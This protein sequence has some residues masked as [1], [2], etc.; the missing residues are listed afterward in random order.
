MQE[1][2]KQ[3]LEKE[4]LLNE[5]LDSTIPKPDVVDQSSNDNKEL[6][7]AKK[8]KQ[9]VDKLPSHLGG[10]Q[11]NGKE[12]GNL[13]DGDNDLG[14]EEDL[15]LGFRDRFVNY[16]SP[17]A[18]RLADFPSGLIKDS[19][20]LVDWM[21]GGPSK[22]KPMT[23]PLAKLINLLSK[24]LGFDKTFKLIQDSIAEDKLKNNIVPDKH[25]DPQKD[26]NL[27]ENKSAQNSIK[28]DLDP[29]LDFGRTKEQIAELEKNGASQ[30]NNQGNN[31]K[32]IHNDL[33]Q[34]LLNDSNKINKSGVK[35]PLI[36]DKSSSSAQDPYQVDNAN[37]D[38]QSENSPMKYKMNHVIR[39]NGVVRAE[40]LPMPHDNKS[41]PKLYNNTK[42]DIGLP[43]KKEA[44][45]VPLFDIDD[46]IDN[47][48]N[49]KP[50]YDKDVDIDLDSNHIEHNVPALG[51]KHAAKLKDGVKKQ[52]TLGH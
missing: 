35:N 40:R 14:A 21:L 39:H 34:M 27:R 24:F 8:A 50:M 43:V 28:P 41:E 1:N 4:N 13:S 3:N 48:E 38:M 15:P 11:A 20:S 33:S 9:D 31:E 26:G 7:M 2:A 51:G 47:L 42:N 22:G 32:N 44:A 45:N 18:K 10:N 30:F 6:E 36:A 49:I 12:T 17:F 29:R 46:D 25:F 23:D 19:R 37:H 5:K 52:P 16:V